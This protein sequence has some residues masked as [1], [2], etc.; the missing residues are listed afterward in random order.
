MKRIRTKLIATLLVIA[1][2]PIYPLYFLVE[3]LLEQSLG[4]GYN[5]NVERAL[6]AATELTRELYAKY[7]HE[8]LATAA[9]LAA[10]TW[11]QKILAGRDGPATPIRRGKLD[12]YDNQGNPVFSLADTSKHVYPPVYQT[13]ISG[14]TQNTE[15][16]ILNI[17]DD[18]RHL[19]AFAPVQRNGE[20]IG[21]L[22]FTN[23]LDKN[24]AEGAQQVV[25]VN[26][27]FKTLD[28]FEGELTGSFLQVFFIVYAP[29]AALSIG[30]GIYFS[31]RITS[32][33]LGLV[34]GTKR[35]AA[36]D[37][38]HR[39]Q[40]NSKDEVGQLVA[41]FNRMTATLQEKQDQ[42]V[43]LE[44]MAVWREIARVLAHEIKNPLTPIQ[45]MVQQIKDK[46]DGDD[47]KYQKLIA[48]CTEII[49]D[50]IENL[51]TLVR[52][53]SEFA[54]MP[55]PNIETG[56][57]NPLIE[58][59]CKLY[60]PEKI[61]LQL[62]SDLPDTQFD[63]EQLRRV[64]IN[65][66]ENGLDSI[67]EKGTG[68]ITIRTEK[69]NGTVILTYKDTGTGVPEEMQKKIF[70]PYFSTKK[71]GMGLG[72]AIVKRIIEEHGGSIAVESQVGEGTRF[73]IVM[74]C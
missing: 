39:V 74:P 63:H 41:S 52:E 21:S 13:T 44:K 36:G 50:E 1:L 58:E 40:V 61:Q 48:D 56:N 4:V 68:E 23:K 65:L 6:D 38:E 7:R 73:E 53:F 43:A 72:L 17:S 16:Q 69:Q 60:P 25:R 19:L 24:I 64:L 20:R 57:L 15:P 67:R 32:P 30:L 35:V 62:A 70:E 66:L 27:I 59:V 31:R 28:F 71:S 12:L 51:R 14:L 46:Y 55:E 2:L 9:E 26:Q 10:S 22:I 8:T 37:W 11:V 49:N 54:R 29:I 3:N 5:E 18:T 42:V 33:L 45:L 34:E 47:P